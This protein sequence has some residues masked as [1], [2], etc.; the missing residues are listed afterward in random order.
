MI[1]IRNAKQS[2]QLKERIYADFAMVGDAEV[3]ERIFE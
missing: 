2:G 3:L 1:N